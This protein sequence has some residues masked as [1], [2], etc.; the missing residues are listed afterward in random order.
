MGEPLREERGGTEIEQSPSVAFHAIVP[1]GTPLVLES[2]S[3]DIKAE[4]PLGHVSAEVSFGDV[5]L[6]DVLGADV[7]A[8][9]GDVTVKGIR[10]GA[11][12]LESSFG[13]VDARGVLTDVD[14]RASSGDVTVTAKSGSK[15]AAPWRIRSSFGDVELTLP[16][17]AACQVRAKTSFGSIDTAVAGT[18]SESTSGGSFHGK[19]GGGGE[20]V[21]LE[22]SSGDVTLTSR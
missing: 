10:G 22:T 8:S 16:A 13:D 1:P 21:T 17:D 3:G 20:L 11:C 19:V 6:F 5:E 12:R 14:A 4:G 18:R 2:S 15:V 7:T 9:S